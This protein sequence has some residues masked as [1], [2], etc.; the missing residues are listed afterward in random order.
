MVAIALK[1]MYCAAMIFC[2]WKFVP[3]NQLEVKAGESKNKAAL[4]G[5]FYVLKMPTVWLAAL[6]SLTVYWT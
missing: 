1:T 6:T 4:Q 2:V 5:L 3:D